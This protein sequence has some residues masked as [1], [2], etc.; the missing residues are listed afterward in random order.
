MAR[1][2]LSTLFVVNAN[3]PGLLTSMQPL[4]ARGVSRERHTSSGYH[5]TVKGVG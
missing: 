5:G 2:G 1:T 3:L 4:A